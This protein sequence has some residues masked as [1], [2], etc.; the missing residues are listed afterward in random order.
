LEATDN[1]PIPGIWSAWRGGL[2]IGLAFGLAMAI[3]VSALPLL[4]PI[5]VALALRGRRFGFDHA[6]LA[7]LGVGAAA[8]VTF[9][10]VSPYAIIDSA[11]FFQQVKTQTD[12]S[13]GA[14]DYPYVRQFSGTI[15]YV[16]EI[17]QMLLYDM[18]LPLAL[19]GLGGFA[20]VAQRVWRRWYDEWA[21]IAVFLV[22]YFAVVGGAY[23]KFT[24]YMLPIFAPLAVCGAAALAALAAWGTRRL[25]LARESTAPASPSSANIL[26]ARLR[27]DPFTGWL[28][29]HA[30]RLYGP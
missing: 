1:A 3:K 26:L 14:L 24:R 19:L 7:A 10:L 15:P 9:C 16:Y 18:G 13:Q 17:Q 28:A 30:T 12:L 2:L 8:I 4:A 22:G 21:I 29:T 6:L 27:G 20:W 11:E 23:V 25:A 5:V